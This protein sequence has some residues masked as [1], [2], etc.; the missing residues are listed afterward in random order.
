MYITPGFGESTKHHRKHTYKFNVKIRVSLLTR[1]SKQMVWSLYIYMIVH[2]NIYT[3]TQNAFKYIST[4]LH[5]CY[6][7]L[8]YSTLVK[9][10]ISSFQIN[11]SFNDMIYLSI[12]HVIYIHISAYVSVCTCFHTSKGAIKSW[13]CVL[14]FIILCYFHLIWVKQGKI[15]INSFFMRPYVKSQKNPNFSSHFLG[16][17]QIYSRYERPR[18]KIWICFQGWRRSRSRRTNK[19]Q[20]LV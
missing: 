6:C 12:I 9:C 18:Y 8:D 16:N 15:N 7:P 13:V 11:V 17:K 5:I 10:F 2:T 1:L 4:N 14:S 3:L 19:K 20:N